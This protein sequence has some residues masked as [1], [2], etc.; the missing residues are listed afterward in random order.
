M[1]FISC[2]EDFV[3]KREAFVPKVVVNSIFTEGKPWK[4]AL[5]FSRDILDNSPNIIP[6][7]NA[8]VY[9][10]RKVN[11]LQI[12]LKHEGA[13]IYTSVTWMPEPDRNY[14]LIV[15]VPGYTTITS[16]STSPSRSEIVNVLSEVVELQGE[17]QTKVNFEIKDNN[18]NF[19]IW[20]VISSNQGKLPDS[21]FTGDAGKLVGSIKKYPSIQSVLNNNV[22]SGNDTESKGGSFSTTTS[23]NN[24]DD[25]LENPPPGSEP[26]NKKYLR[27]VTASGDLY[28]Y[29]KSVEQFVLSENYN[30]SIAYTTKVY[31]NIQ[32][33]LG[34]FA[35]YTEKYIEI[36]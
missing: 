17:K 32:N 10:I 1:V 26:I 28:N 3:L 6:V 5:T 36:K 2:E 20:N 27:V 25:S 24:G 35:G 22:L 9:I 13:G 34:I 15:N 21:S 19:Y 23:D 11:G 12:P 29:Y 30:T 8:D 18:S 7:E 33:G 14:E 16:K 4:V 31:S